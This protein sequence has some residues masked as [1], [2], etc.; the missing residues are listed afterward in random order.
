MSLT[1][2]N[3]RTPHYRLV[4]RSVVS[5]RKRIIAK[6]PNLYRRHLLFT[7]PADY[8]CPLTQ[9]AAGFIALFPAILSIRT[10]TE[11][12]SAFVGYWRGGAGASP[13][14]RYRMGGKATV[15]Q[16]LNDY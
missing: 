3:E 14:G 11:W 6:N 2:C 5:F 15:E 13:G 16:R 9:K 1:T 8:V 12:A 4:S 10:R 7:Y